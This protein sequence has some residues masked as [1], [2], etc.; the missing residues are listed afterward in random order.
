MITQIEFKDNDF[1]NAERIAKELGFNQTAYTSTSELI[2]LFCI[3]DAEQYKRAK[4]SGCIIK[5]K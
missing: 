4:K 2:G 1:E 5:S 3:L